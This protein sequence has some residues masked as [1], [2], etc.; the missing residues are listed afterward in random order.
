MLYSKSLAFI[1]K[2]KHFSFYAFAIEV[3]QAG[4]VRGRFALNRTVSAM[5]LLLFK[6]VMVTMPSAISTLF[7]LST[8]ISN[9]LQ[10]TSICDSL[11]LM[12]V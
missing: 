12:H 8:A 4:D 11:H 1:F 9:D 7:D 3:V 2:V 6:I 10:F 5:E